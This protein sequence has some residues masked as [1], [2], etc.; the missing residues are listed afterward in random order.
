MRGRIVMDSAR[1]SAAGGR[2]LEL[3]TVEGVCAVAKSFYEQGGCETALS[4]ADALLKLCDEAGGFSVERLRAQRELRIFKDAP[5]Q[6]IEEVAAAEEETAYV[7]PVMMDQDTPLVLFAAYGEGEEDVSPLSAILP[8]TD[9]MRLEIERC[10]L[11]LL[12]HPRL[13]ARL[14]ARI[15][16]PH[17]LRMIQEMRRHEALQGRE[18]GMGGGG[19]SPETRRPLMKEVLC[20]GEDSTHVAANKACIARLVFYAQTTS[21]LIRSI[22][23]QPFFQ[24]STREAPPRQRRIQ[25]LF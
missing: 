10:P 17:G 15:Q 16:P 24:T 20:F 21:T 5:D 7:D 25:L 22:L 13:D 12:C 14:S 8:K 2:D 23:P 1:A 11:L 6:D 19:R 18:E 9:P 3:L 4:K